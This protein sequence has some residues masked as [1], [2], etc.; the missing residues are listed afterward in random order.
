MSCVLSD[1]LA[2]RGMLVCGLTACELKGQPCLRERS[3]ASLEWRI[4]AAMHCSTV[5][6]L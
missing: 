1:L 2:L 6:R 4:C 5:P 3:V